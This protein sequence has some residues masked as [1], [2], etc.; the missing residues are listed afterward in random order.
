MAVIGSI[1]RRSGLLIGVIVVALVLFLISDMFRNPMSA[2]APMETEEDMVTFDG[3]D[4]SSAVIDSLYGKALK[5]LYYDGRLGNLFIGDKLINDVQAARD[6]SLAMQ[7]LF[8]QDVDALGG[9]SLSTK[10]DLQSMIV[11]GESASLFF[12]N[13]IFDSLELRKDGKMDLD[14]LVQVINNAS[15]SLPGENNN[16]LVQNIV[17]EM[18]N[19]RTI[20][21]NLALLNT[22]LR[23]PSW[24]NKTFDELNQNGGSGLAQNTSNKASET[25]IY[26]YHQGYRFAPAAKI[27]FFSRRQ[28]LSEDNIRRTR[29]E[30]LDKAME[31]EDPSSFEV[32]DLTMGRAVLSNNIDF[33]NHIEKFKST[34]SYR[35]ETNLDD[36]SCTAV[37]VKEAFGLSFWKASPTISMDS[38]LKVVASDLSEESIFDFATTHDLIAEDDLSLKSAQDVNAWAKDYSSPR[39]YHDSVGRPDIL[40]V[41]WSMDNPVDFSVVSYAKGEFAA[42][43]SESSAQFTLLAKEELS[44][45][46][47]SWNANAL[48]YSD[49]LTPGYS[50]IPEI[51]GLE[52]NKEAVNWIFAHEVGSDSVFVSTG[53][54]G[55]L[56]SHFIRIDK[57]VSEGGINAK[58]DL[59]NATR[60][61]KIY[62]NTTKAN[63][64][65]L[66]AFDAVTTSPIWTPMTADVLNF[67]NNRTHSELMLDL[68][69]GLRNKKWS[70]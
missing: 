14:L 2:N 22:G 41:K 51:A 38:I 52:N 66:L 26:N 18:K 48:R 59:P 33:T 19:V 40:V 62:K 5:D 24:M 3:V 12:E 7:L 60:N 43:S 9:I 6:Y 49:W 68:F 58:E 31:N 67:T 29:S 47:E 8:Q 35:I 63:L 64:P 53:E 61:F 25:K 27:S 23:S 16:A 69:F 10:A 32:V 57:I 39:F 37:H 55:I 54:N 20:N 46:S 44:T 17:Q 56:T 34:G 70:F 11:H 50:G 30:A 21:F 28:K 42:P 45:I 4:T 36:F 1:R 15:S 13:S 65:N